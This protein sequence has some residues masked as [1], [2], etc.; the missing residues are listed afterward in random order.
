MTL[1]F[2]LH[3]GSEF[4]VIMAVSKRFLST[5]SILAAPA[6]LWTVF[7]LSSDIAYGGNKHGEEEGVRLADAS[8]VSG[9]QAGKSDAGNDAQ[10]S[11]S[12]AQAGIQ[13]GVQKVH[14][15]L[16]KLRDVGLD[17]KQVT[18][19]ARHL[20]DEVTIQPVSV[21]TEPEVVGRGIIIN[22]PIGTRP[23]GLPQP[24][25]PKRVDQSMTIMRPIISTLKQ[26]AD[27]FVLQNKELDVSPEAKEKLEP[28]VKKWVE[29]A[30]NIGGQLKGLEP[31]T[32][33]PAYDNSS[34]AAICVNIQQ[35]A[36]L[37]DKVR[38]DA[39]KIIKKEEKQ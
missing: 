27:D 38:R 19:S 11:N 17:L 7:T 26:N 16:E 15:S 33:G 32:K 1:T 5:F 29:L 13:G 3:F 9:S 20:Y 10:G 24:P 37:L 12:Q 23:V 8:T 14:I 28:L 30:D 2:A 4:E 6:L 34:I 36:F 21:I 18:T 31:L 35:D 39:F 25:N 22:I